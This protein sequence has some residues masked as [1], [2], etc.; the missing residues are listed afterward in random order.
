MKRPIVELYNH[1]QIPE[2][3]KQ[4]LLTVAAIG[5]TIIQNWDTTA[6]L[7]NELILITLLTHDLGNLA[8]FDLDSPLS[9]R[10]LDEQGLDYWKRR[11]Q[12]F[13]KKYGHDAHQANLKIV[14]ELGLPRA[15]TEILKRQSFVNLPN[16]LQS[17]KPHTWET[18]ICLYSDLRVTPSGLASI[19]SRI[20][21]LQ[22]RY[23][24]RD[25]KW[26]NAETVKKWH[27]QSA[28]LESQINQKTTI[29]LPDLSMKKI[30]PLITELTRYQIET[31][32]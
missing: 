27:Q 21:D 12:Q 25:I 18:K 4:H 20:N 32:L 6:T 15:V 7:D 9:Q 11:Q 23:G 5:L 17:V 10:Y 14:Q 2:N 31:T 22:K 30:A 13:R 16:L 26:Q 29:S 8:K 3:L 28:V 24:Y 1:Y 19:E